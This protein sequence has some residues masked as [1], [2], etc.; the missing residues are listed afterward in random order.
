MASAIMTVLVWNS[1]QSHAALLTLGPVRLHSAWSVTAARSAIRANGFDRRLGRGTASQYE[2]VA[3]LRGESM[4]RSTKPPPGDR[5]PSLARVVREYATVV[6]ALDRVLRRG[7]TARYCLTH[8]VAPPPPK[9]GLRVLP[10]LRGPVAHG[11]CPALLRSGP[12]GAHPSAPLAATGIP[13]NLQTAGR[14]HS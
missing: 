2:I 4:I 9:R 13:S 11:G 10:T 12:Q 7:R 3:V 1:K 14:R 6:H 8:G 5:Y